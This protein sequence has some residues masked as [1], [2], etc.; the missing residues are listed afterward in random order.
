MQMKWE[1]FVHAYDPHHRA[2]AY[3][4]NGPDSTPHAPVRESRHVQFVREFAVTTASL[5]EKTDTLISIYDDMLYCL[6]ELKTCQYTESLFSDI[7]RR[8]QDLVNACRIPS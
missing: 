5:Q 6:N 2:G 7:L 8:I 4:S 1:S 3:L